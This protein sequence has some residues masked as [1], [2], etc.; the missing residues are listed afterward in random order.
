M[1]LISLIALFA[2]GLSAQTPR[3]TPR[4][5]M[6]GEA[7]GAL[8]WLSAPYIVVVKIQGAEWLGPAL[9]VT[10]PEKTVVRLVGVDG[11]IENVIQGDIPVGRVRFYFFANTL[12]SGGFTT[13]KYWLAPGRR[14]VA[15]LRRDGG[16]VRT[17]ADVAPP[18]IA[19]FSGRHRAN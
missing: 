14:Y 6:P 18:E 19:I 15:F 17:M 1:P 13:V 9:E 7:P 4:I 16:V 2:V 8:F 12:S 11:E 10:P 5:I 3:L